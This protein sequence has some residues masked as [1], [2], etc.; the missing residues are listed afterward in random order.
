MITV[1]VH[2]WPR[3]QVPMVLL[4]WELPQTRWSYA[5]TVT[6]ERVYRS[7]LVWRH[8]DLSAL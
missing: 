5:E 1:S 8:R 4:K 3:T 7:L 2:P 6:A